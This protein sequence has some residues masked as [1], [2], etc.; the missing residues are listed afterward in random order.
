MAL[1]RKERGE[2]HPGRPRIADKHGRIV[3][4]VEALIAADLPE[5][6]ET[7]IR[8]LKIHAPER[9]SEHGLVLSC[10]ECGKMSQRTQYN[11]KDAQYLF[12]RIMGK[13]TTRSENTLTVQFVEQVVMAFIV[14]FG[15]IN[16][17]GDATA[18][19]EA[20]SAK[21]TELGLLFGGNA[22]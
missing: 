12:D 22:A 3:N 14:A 20:F 7:Y 5:E 6:I 9:C 17:L 4:R 18:R 10:S 13:P 8:E 1:L 21:C 16:G 2:K 19:G 15:E 11:H